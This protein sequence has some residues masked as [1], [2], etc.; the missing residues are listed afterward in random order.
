MT[1]IK[2]LDN[3]ANNIIGYFENIKSDWS[4]NLINMIQEG[5]SKNPYQSD[6]N[7]N[8]YNYHLMWEEQ[9]VINF[10]LLYMSSLYLYCYAKH[11]KCD[12]FLFAT[13]DC[14]HWIKIF[15]KLF[16]KTNCHYFDCSRNMLQRATA[17]KNIYYNEYVKSVIN[18]NIRKNIYVDIHGTG[19]SVFSYFKTEF[20]NYPHCFLLSVCSQNYKQLP[21]VCLKPYKKDRFSIMVYNAAGSPIEMLN[22]DLMGTL[23][24]YNVH[25]AVRSPQEYPNQH[26]QPYHDC[27]KLL[28]DQIKPI[29]NLHHINDKDF[30]KI[31]N[32]IYSIILHDLPIVSKFI[33]HQVKHH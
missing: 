32:K 31:I 7:S 23:Q 14:C 2:K 21:D 26:V 6:I 27:M 3:F 30:P 9:C 12:T 18:Q 24:D 17:Q 16:P 22:Y 19:K 13:R 28:I 25:G 5:R 29:K 4:I 20:D 11:E 10:P 15:K 33:T 8:E 1:A